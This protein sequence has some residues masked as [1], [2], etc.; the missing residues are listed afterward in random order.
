[1]ERVSSRQREPVYACAVEERG[2][3]VLKRLVE[4]GDAGP[5]AE[6]GVHVGM[7]FYSQGN[8]RPA[9]GFSRTTGHWSK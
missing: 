6:A 4:T 2:R 8:A 7:G 9:E 3:G 1:M 5:G